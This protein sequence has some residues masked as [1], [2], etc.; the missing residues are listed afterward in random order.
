MNSQQPVCHLDEIEDGTARGFEIG[1]GAIALRLLI[2]RQGTDI[3]AY[4]NSCPHTG[5]NLE[6]LPD[7]FLDSSAQYIQCAMHGAMFRIE[8]GFCVSGPCAGDALVAI[9]VDLQDGEVVCELPP[10]LL[11]P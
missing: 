7:Q 6:W 9:P 1:E 5:V 10:A 4:R 11:A 2:V 8:D 3:Y